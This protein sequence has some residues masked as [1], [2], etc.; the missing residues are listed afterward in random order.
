MRRRGGACDSEGA[1]LAGVW[2]KWRLDLGEPY[3]ACLSE[4]VAP[5]HLPDGTEVVVKVQLPEDVESEHEA[6]AL[7]FWA[8]HGAVRLLAH[9][10]A[11]RALLLEHCRPGTPLAARYDDEALVIAAALMQRLWRP[12]PGDVQWRR[13]E[14]EAERWLVEFPERFEQHGRPFERR[15]LA[16]ALD[17]VRTLAPT[18]EDAVLCHQDLHGGNILRAER[19]PW[20]AIDPKPIV[21]E[22]AYDTVAIVR[23]AKPTRDELRRRLDMLSDL[24]G[25]DR[26][27]MRLWGIA[28]SLAWDGASEAQL[29]WEVGSRR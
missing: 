9:D 24:L 21:A 6:E 23:D 26:E 19:E 5:A 15:L 25:L 17:A 29:Y 13:L 10:P 1:G 2:S 12:P 28:K 22:R 20:L 27:R 7:R 14:T 4:L 3:E 11:H 16:A 18:Q 8:G